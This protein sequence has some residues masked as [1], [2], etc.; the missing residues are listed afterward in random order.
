[1]SLVAEVGYRMTGKK[2]VTAEF[3]EKLFG[4]YRSP[5]LWIELRY[6]RAA[7]FSDRAKIVQSW[8]PANRTADIVEVIHKE[9]SLFPH[10]IHYGPSLR[11]SRTGKK[12]SAAGFN[13]FWTDIDGASFESFRRDRLPSLERIGAAPNIVVSSGWGLHVFWVVRT[14]FPDIEAGE[15]VNRFVAWLLSGDKA[16]S[17]ISHMLRMPG[18]YNCKSSPPRATDMWTVRG[19]PYVTESLV[20]RFATMMEMSGFAAEESRSGKQSPVRKNANME[21]KTL[22]PDSVPEETILET[23]PLLKNALDGKQSEYQWYATGCAI[24]NVFGPDGEKFFHSLSARDSRYS[25]P[26]TSSKWRSICSAGR[27]APGCERV[28]DEGSCDAL[29]SGICK[30]LMGFLRRK[31]EKKQ[32]H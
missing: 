11:K 16:A 19:A 12:D 24:F 13:C 6:N 8:Y 26:E 30:N 22:S 20:Q 4:L 32:K 28:I 1:M 5:D 23:C 9:S 15:R 7:S 25:S 31:A 10:N 18:S 2:S 29:S 3:L 27:A 17:G 21:R 14:M